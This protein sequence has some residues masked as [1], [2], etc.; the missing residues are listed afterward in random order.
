MVSGALRNKTKS[1][2]SAPKTEG[3]NHEAALKVA[4]E[5]LPAIENE[6]KF[7]QV[8][9]QLAKLLPEIAHGLANQADAATEDPAEAQRL[10]EIATEA[11]G[12]CNTPKYVSKEFRDDA[13]LATIEETLARVTQRQKTRGELNAAV[14]ATNFEAWHSPKPRK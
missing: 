10:V 4:K 2:I 6:P 14:S 5:V 7:A 1:A 11:L 9:D 8:R 12:L 13:E 3:G